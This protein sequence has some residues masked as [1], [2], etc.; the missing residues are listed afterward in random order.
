M[1]SCSFPSR[2]I[3]QAYAPIATNEREYAQKL[4]KRVV[5]DGTA[6]RG[7]VADQSFKEASRSSWAIPSNVA[8]SAAASDRPNT[9]SNLS[10]ATHHRRTPS[11]HLALP[12]E[13][14]AMWRRRPSTALSPKTT[15]PSRSRGL[16][17]WPS[18]ERSIANASASSASVGGSVDQCASSDR[19]ASWV[20]RSPQGSSA[21]S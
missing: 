18:D 13:V 3:I 16:R 5:G 15:K 2:G 7:P 11:R 14:N 8:R 4:Q 12:L 10:C 9:C 17:L 1:H 6:R 20:D 19:I 21:A